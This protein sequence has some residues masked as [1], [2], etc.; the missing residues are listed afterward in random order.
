MTPPG[1][2]NLFMN[3]ASDLFMQ[4]H[5]E[6]V[7]MKDTDGLVIGSFYMEQCYI[8]AFSLSVDA[9]GIIWQEGVQVQFERLVPVKLTNAIPLIKPFWDA[10]V[11]ADLLSG[12]RTQIGAAIGQGMS[13]NA[14]AAGGTIYE[15]SRTPFA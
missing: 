4:P 7:L 5:G 10:P 1:Y 2:D 13:N 8:P 6:L 12:M 3:L 11:G 9:Q 15:A 14:R